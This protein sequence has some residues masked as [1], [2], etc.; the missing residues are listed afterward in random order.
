MDGQSTN[1]YLT[2]YCDMYEEAESSHKK[3]YIFYL[4]N[5][6]L[7]RHIHCPKD[8]VIDLEVVYH[9][10]LENEADDIN[11]IPRANGRLYCVL[12]KLYCRAR[13]EKVPLFIAAVRAYSEPVADELLARWDGI[14]KFIR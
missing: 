2:E 14:S 8:F 5:A 10:L 9:L 6:V 1:D 12:E 11:N 4:S 3:G 13:W 7:I